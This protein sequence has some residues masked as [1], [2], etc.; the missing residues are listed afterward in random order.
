VNNIENKMLEAMSMNDVA[1]TEQNRNSI[2]SYSNSNL[3]S[4]KII[5]P[6]KSD[7]SLIIACKKWFTFYI[8][9]ANKMSVIID[10]IM[11]KENFE[12]QKELFDAKPA[13]TRTNDDINNYNNALK[14]FNAAVETYNKTINE[15]NQKRAKLYDEWKNCIDNFLSKHI[16]K[17]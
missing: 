10:F 15:L 12:K 9:E 13:K 16:P 11:K 3:D 8:E 14:E 4:L 2:I 1:S 5:K 6:Y 7:N 17:K